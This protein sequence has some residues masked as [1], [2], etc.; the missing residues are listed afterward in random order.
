MSDILDTGGEVLVSSNTV[1]GAVGSWHDGDL[2]QSFFTTALKRCRQSG[3]LC[4]VTIAMSL[5]IPWRGP[6]VD[7]EPGW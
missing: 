3:L 7:P 1:D 5:W 2:L 4:K 6:P